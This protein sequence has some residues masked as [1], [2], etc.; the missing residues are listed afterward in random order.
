MGW[1]VYLRP[2]VAKL[3]IGIMLFGSLSAFPMG[4]CLEGGTVFGFPYIFYSQCNNLGPRM[5]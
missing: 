1:K 3:V 2:D 5:S 4:Y